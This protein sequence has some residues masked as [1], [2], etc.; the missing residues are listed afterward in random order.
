MRKLKLGLQK[1]GNARCNNGESKKKPRLQEK[2]HLKSRP[3]R[4]KITKLRKRVRKQPTN[5]KNQSH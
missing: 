3:K 2:P 4:M 5:K 1:N